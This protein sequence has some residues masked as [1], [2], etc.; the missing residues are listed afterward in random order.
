MPGLTPFRGDDVNET[1]ER[2]EVWLANG[3]KY[4]GHIVDVWPGHTSGHG[5]IVLCEDDRVFVLIHRAHVARIRRVGPAT[6]ALIPSP[7]PGPI[8]T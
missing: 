7:A 3:K 2:V 4:S 5:S 8:A 6:T 1:E